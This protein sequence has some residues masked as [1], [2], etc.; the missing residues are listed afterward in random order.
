[1]VNED[2]PAISDPMAHEFGVEKARSFKDG[3]E[4]LLPGTLEANKAF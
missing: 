3:M 4:Q 1:M 2:L